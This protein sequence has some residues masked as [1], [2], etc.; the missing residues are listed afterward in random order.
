MTGMFLLL[1]F[2]VAAEGERP[3]SI[4]ARKRSNR[5]T[6]TVSMDL[7]GLG[8]PQDRLRQAEESGE[9]DG[10]EID[11]ARWAALRRGWERAHMD[12]IDEDG[13]VKLKS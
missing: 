10:Y 5:R 3:T 4:V 11:N 8:T 9:L 1:V 12:E 2:C 13:S 6:S 7:T